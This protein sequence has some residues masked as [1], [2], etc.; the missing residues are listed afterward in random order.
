MRFVARLLAVAIVVVLLPIVGGN[1]ASARVG[2][3]GG[4]SLGVLG[5]LW[6][7]LWLPRSAHDAF[8]AGKYAAAQ[9]RYR[10][11][12]LLAPSALRERSALLSR[13]GCFVAAGHV[14]RAEQLLATLDK[15]QLAAAERAVW[16]NNRACAELAAGRDPQAALALVDEATALRPDVP[17]VQHTRGMAL[18]AVGRI[19]DAIAVLDGMRAAGELP[20]RLEAERCRDLAKAWS[21]K[22]ET[23]YAEDYR[24]RADALAR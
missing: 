18:L 15:A 9:R 5:L 21:Q 6:V 4:V 17:A 19:D 22:G 10:L 7:W 11:I 23:A 16:L 8:E 20:A 3:L 1:L 24:L 12:G 14:D 2:V 13:A